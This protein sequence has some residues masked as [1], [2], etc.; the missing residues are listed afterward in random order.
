[1]IYGVVLPGQNT[2]L[3]PDK[4]GYIYDKPYNPLKPP[5]ATY[6][7]SSRSSSKPAYRP[8]NLQSPNPE[9]TRPQIQ[10]GAP[11]SSTIRPLSTSYG[12]H[13]VSIPNSFQTARP[14]LTLIPGGSD[15][16]TIY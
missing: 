11:V 2:Y 12:P 14:P 8:P 15:N 16:V 1:M 13:I 9:Y 10:Y 6:K 4:S 5:T 7:P 3:P